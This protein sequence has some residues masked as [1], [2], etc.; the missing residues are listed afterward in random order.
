[1]LFPAHV[2]SQTDYD[3]ELVYMPKNAR[4]KLSRC[5][6]VVAA[7]CIASASIALP[8]A[9]AVSAGHGADTSPLSAQASKSEY[10]S[11]SSSENG[12][13]YTIGSP[14]SITVNA[15]M[16]LFGYYG[17][18]VPNYIA[19]KVTKGGK[20]VSYDSVSYYATGSQDWTFTPSKPGKYRSRSRPA[21]PL[22][23]VTRT[24]KPST[25]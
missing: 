2:S 8:G 4:T 5:T 23:R 13:A 22:C 20:K 17:S 11:I 16:Y 3:E 19:I 25:A 24:L 12:A 9:Y 6:M 18:N 14:V 10:F 1:M 21:A 15:G 7:A